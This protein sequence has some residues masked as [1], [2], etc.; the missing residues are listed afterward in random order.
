MIRVRC[1][2]ELLALCYHPDTS[3]AV[4]ARARS[5]GEHPHA[6]CLRRAG[7]ET[8]AQVNT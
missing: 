8:V 1:L 5:R 2:Q 6:G 7:S 4:P 3:T